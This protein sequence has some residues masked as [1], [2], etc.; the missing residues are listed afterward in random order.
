MTRRE[1]ML[2]T[3]AGARLAM[4]E[5]AAAAAQACCRSPQHGCMSSCKRRMRPGLGWRLTSNAMYVCSSR[6]CSE[7]VRQ[8]LEAGGQLVQT[9]QMP[10]NDTVQELAGDVQLGRVEGWTGEAKRQE[11]CGYACMCV[12]VCFC[13]RVFVC[14]YAW[15]VGSSV[16]PGAEN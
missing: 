1:A 7:S 6:S 12:C 4:P 13:A 9:P 5:E 2:A 8:W 16:R 15:A 14:G 11:V 3:Q 10:K